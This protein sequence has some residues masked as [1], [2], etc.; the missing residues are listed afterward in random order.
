ML[1]EN[2][3]LLRVGEKQETHK[4]RGVYGALKAES[5]YLTAGQGNEGYKGAQPRVCEH[6]KFEN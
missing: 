5:G 2:W 6:E 3:G 1:E 4:K